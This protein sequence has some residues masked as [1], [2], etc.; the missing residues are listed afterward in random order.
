MSADGRKSSVETKVQMATA[1]L[2]LSN[3][4]Q[5]NDMLA[6]CYTAL[7]SQMNDYVRKMKEFF[8]YEGILCSNNLT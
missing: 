5:A 1:I 3:L 8:L 6:Q 2:C 4:P 7:D